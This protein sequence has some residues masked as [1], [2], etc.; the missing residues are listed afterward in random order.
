M[1]EWLTLAQMR[2]RFPNRRKG[3]S[4]TLEQLLIACRTKLQL[5]RDAHSGEY[6]GGMEYSA[7]RRELDAAIERLAPQEDAAQ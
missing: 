1:V 7:L 4:M 3:G 2:E 6:I 5:Y